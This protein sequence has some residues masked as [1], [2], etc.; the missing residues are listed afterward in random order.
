MTNRLETLLNMA[1]SSPNPDPFLLF[2]LAKE[3]EGTGD[4][5]NALSHYEGLVQKHESY[6]GTYY[7]FGKL[8]AQRGN[9]Q[10]ALEVLGKGKLVSKSQ[11]DFHA[12]AEL[13]GLTE[14]LE[15]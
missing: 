4:L 11:K 6:V 2:A 13:N 9:I 8:L 1:A 12:L 10:K 5:E 7:H 15:P 3:Y 14:E